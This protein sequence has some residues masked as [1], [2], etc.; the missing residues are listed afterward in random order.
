MRQ[1]LRTGVHTGL[2]TLRVLVTGLC[3]AGTDKSTL[4]RQRL[5]RA[6]SSGNLAPPLRRRQNRWRTKLASR[7]GRSRAAWLGVT[8][9][10]TFTT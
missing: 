7:S 8:Q 5:V 9:G 4:M 1:P 10:L 2:L 6:R 3:A